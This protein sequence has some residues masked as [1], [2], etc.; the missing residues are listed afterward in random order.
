M[1][2]RKALR[3]GS[4]GVE[5]AVDFNLQ[6]LILRSW[7][8]STLNASTQLA[9]LSSSCSLIV[10][11]DELRLRCH[12]VCWDVSRQINRTSHTHTL[13]SDSVS[14]GL[15]CVHCAGARTVGGVGRM[16]EEERR[17]GFV[18]R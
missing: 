13:L 10:D 15:R 9:L 1:R 16:R 17:S 11:D 6:R 8:R 7:L 12:P 4:A 5:L 18:E 14:V 3:R 2:I